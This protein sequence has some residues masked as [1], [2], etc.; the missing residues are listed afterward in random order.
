MSSGK[1]LPTRFRIL[2]LVQGAGHNT[3]I[4]RQSPEG[5]DLIAN[6]REALPN[7]VTMSIEKAYRDF[8]TTWRR[9][10]AGE[11]GFRRLSRCVVETRSNVVGEIPDWDPAALPGVSAKEALVWN[12]GYIFLT[13]EMCRQARVAAAASRPVGCATGSVP[14]KPK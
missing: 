6:L 5:H 11:A 3:G 8:A 12:A 10:L 1:A 14:P 4:A 13:V 2:R 7:D 9:A